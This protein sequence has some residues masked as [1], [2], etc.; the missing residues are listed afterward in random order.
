M[1]R[2]L[3]ESQSGGS[4]PQFLSSHPNPGNRHD[5]IQKDIQGWPPVKYRTDNAAFERVKQ[6]A[7][8]VKTYTAE[9]IAQGAK[10]GQWA[11]LNRKNGAL[12]TPPPG[13]VP[14]AQQQ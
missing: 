3:G 12:L 14:A 1:D 13:M 2:A 9:E 5:A 11:A 7:Q 10:S 4:G 8:G 6:Q